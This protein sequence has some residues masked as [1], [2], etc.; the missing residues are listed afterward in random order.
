[1]RQTRISTLAR[2][3]VKKDLQIPSPQPTTPHVP[4]ANH[5][6]DPNRS[7]TVVQ[8]ELSE[9]TPRTFPAA[10]YDSTLVLQSHLHSHIR[11]NIAPRLSRERSTISNNNP[12]SRCTM[13]YPRRRLLL[14]PQSLHQRKSTQRWT[15]SCRCSRNIFEVYSLSCHI[16]E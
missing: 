6:P 5:T 16:Y 3:S 4:P 8:S 10:P 14:A 13:P 1:M 11:I 2:E 9:P 12:L 7:Y 15:S